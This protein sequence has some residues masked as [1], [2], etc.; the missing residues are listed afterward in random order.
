MTQIGNTQQRP[1]RIHAR[2][3]LPERR[4]ISGTARPVEHFDR[5]SDQSLELLLRGKSARA[6][7]T[8]IH[9]TTVGQG[10]EPS[11]VPGLT[12][13]MTWGLFDQGASSVTNLGLSLLAGRLLGPSGLGTI[14]VGFSAYLLILA[15]QRAVLSEPAVILS[16]REDRSQ[17]DRATRAATSSTIL[18]GTFGALVMAAVGWLIGGRFGLGLLLFSPWLLPSLLQDLWRMLL[19]RD[20][21][22]RAAVFNDVVWLVGMLALLPL[23]VAHPAGWS[24]VSM[25]GAGASLGALLGFIQI[26]EFGSRPSDSFVWVKEEAWPLGRWFVAEGLVTMGA[27]QGSVFVVAG[28]LGASAV[29]GLRAMGVLFAPLSM[30]GP[31]IAL[32]GLPLV[33]SALRKSRR[34]ATAIAVRISILLTVITIVFFAVTVSWRQ[35]L[36]S[37]V[38]GR[39]FVVYADLI[40]PVGVQQ[41]FAAI[42]AGFVLLMKARRRGRFILFYRSLVSVT[43]LFAVVGL[44]LL[45]GLVGAAWGAAIGTAI[46]T[47]TVIEATWRDSRS[48]TASA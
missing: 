4:R 42:A 25:W 1:S 8:E 7:R 46:G 39:K 12:A 35:V 40:W 48:S 27:I 33:A 15:F 41:V 44:S 2:Y 34:A 45:F 3:C 11:R 36:L 32:P 37:Y 18:L 31:A 9:V 20:G 26:R 19:F 24:I 16:S 23:V 5:Q 38:F 10:L 29:G 28:L 6:E 47:C 22:E 43:M 21:R 30:L 14:T 17:W 13:K